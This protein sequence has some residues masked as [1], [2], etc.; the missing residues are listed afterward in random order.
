MSQLKKSGSRK[1][2]EMRELKKIKRALELSKELQH[3]EENINSINMRSRSAPFKK[4]E[5]KEKDIYS[6]EKKFDKRFDNVDVKLDTI[7]DAINNL[8]PLMFFCFERFCLCLSF[9]LLYIFLL[10]EGV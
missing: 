5:K 3:Y 8:F 2:N 4:D 6:L 9:R 10:D 7:H 1:L